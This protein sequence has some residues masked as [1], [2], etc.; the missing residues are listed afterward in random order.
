MRGFFVAAIEEVFAPYRDL[1]EATEANGAGV[2]VASLASV[3]S[4]EADTDPED[5]GE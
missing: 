2:S 4:S 3:R 5:D 1:T